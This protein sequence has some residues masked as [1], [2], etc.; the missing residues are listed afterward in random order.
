MKKTIYILLMF[1][2]F[3]GGGGLATTVLNALAAYVLNMQSANLYLQMALS[4]PLFALKIMILY[5]LFLFLKSRS[6]VIPNEFSGFTA[7]IGYLAL[8]LSALAVL[9][10][11]MMFALQTGPGISGI[12]LA[13]IFVITVLMSSICVF[14]SELRFLLNRK[15]AAN[16]PSVASK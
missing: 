3:F 11:L 10:Y 2:T 15:N 14:V 6:I 4:L 5:R 13:F 9:G 1:I 8:G 7:A 16:N 12:P